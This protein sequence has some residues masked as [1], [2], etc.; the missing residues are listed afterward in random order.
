M[1]RASQ[2]LNLTSDSTIGYKKWG[3]RARRRRY[4]PDRMTR[5]AVLVDFG[6]VLTTS[7]G[8]AFEDFGASVGK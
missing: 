7:V 3:R 6:G 1:I 5:N 8:Q 2:K 4:F